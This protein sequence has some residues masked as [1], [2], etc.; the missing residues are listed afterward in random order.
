WSSYSQWLRA[1]PCAASHG[2]DLPSDT[3]AIPQRYPITSVPGVPRRLRMSAACPP[4]GGPSVRNAAT[5]QRAQRAQARVGPTTVAP[6]PRDAPPP[7][8]DTPPPA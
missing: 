7:P 3:P 5:P 1:T 6:P 8:R 2:E 4:H